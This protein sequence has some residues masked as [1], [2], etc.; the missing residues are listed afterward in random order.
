MMP[1][2]F[3]I[4]LVFW[5]SLARLLYHVFLVFAI[6]V[7]SVI[8]SNANYMKNLDLLNVVA[9]LMPINIKMVLIVIIY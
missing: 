7:V 3:L 4:S 1:T 2:S 6:V 9:Y 8:A 5:I